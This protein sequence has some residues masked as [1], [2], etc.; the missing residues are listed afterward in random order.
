MGSNVKG[1]LLY[2]LVWNVA[3]YAGT[4]AL[5]VWLSTLTHDWKVLTNTLPS[6]FDPREMV[7]I[8]IVTF[9]PLGM[10]RAI[11]KSPLSRQ[12]DQALNRRRLMTAGLAAAITGVIVV[13]ILSL[14]TTL[15]VFTLPAFQPTFHNISFGLEMWYRLAPQL[16][17]FVLPSFFAG[18]V[19][20]ISPWISA[21]GSIV[22]NSVAQQRGKRG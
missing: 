8:I 4:L 22:G 10:F 6:L 1:L 21:R 19:A 18:L 15:F 17:I 16:A 5:L 2:L 11:I 13:A 7:I 14:F 9:I 20:A 3:Y 12:S